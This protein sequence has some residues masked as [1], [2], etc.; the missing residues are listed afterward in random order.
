MA[1][2]KPA[3]RTVV[4]RFVEEARIAGQDEDAGLDVNLSGVCWSIN[5]EVPTSVIVAIIPLWE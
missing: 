3:L 1:G 5:G 4:E 2:G